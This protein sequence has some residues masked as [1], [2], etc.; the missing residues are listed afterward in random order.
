M[1][2]SYTDIHAFQNQTGTG[3]LSVLCSTIQWPIEQFELRIL[4]EILFVLSKCSFQ[5]E[6]DRLRFE[7]QENACLVALEQEF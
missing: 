4:V 3:Q 2:P 1:K 5:I 7:R 6:E